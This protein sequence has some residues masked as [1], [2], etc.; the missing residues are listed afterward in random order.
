ML[1]KN[2]IYCKKKG[3]MHENNKINSKD[4]LWS[5]V[6]FFCFSYKINIAFFS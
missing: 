1:I 2:D 3:G 4:D 6:E 5:G